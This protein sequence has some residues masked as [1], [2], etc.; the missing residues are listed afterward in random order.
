MIALDSYLF[1]FVSGNWFAL[2][3]V[4]GLLKIISKMTPWVID[5]QIHTLLAGTF[6]LMK[7]PPQAGLQD[8]ENRGDE[9]PGYT[10]IYPQNQT[11]KTRTQSGS[12]LPPAP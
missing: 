8:M 12:Q 9:V 7:K 2:S 3:L 10:S 4:L 6:G 11:S 5:D 1:Q